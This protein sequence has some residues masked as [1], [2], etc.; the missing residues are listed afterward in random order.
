VNT[1]I[2]FAVSCL[3]S[4]SSLACADNIELSCTRSSDEWSTYVVIDVVGKS[5]IDNKIKG[6]NVSIDKNTISYDL[7]FKKE[8]LKYNVKINRT[9][10]RMLVINLSNNVIENLYNCEPVNPK[11]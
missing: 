5:V 1:K 4:F 10:G 3:V 9:S 11:F 8:T 7:V 6:E 2:I